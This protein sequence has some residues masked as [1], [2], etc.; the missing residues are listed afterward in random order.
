MVAVNVGA[1]SLGSLYNWTSPALPQLSRPDSWLPIDTEQASW[2]GS[3]VSLSSIFGPFIGGVS[4][5][6]IGRKSSM[7]VAVV[8]GLVAWAILYFTTAVWHIYVS[9][10]IAGLGGG[11]IFTSVPLYI[12]EI[13][14]VSLPHSARRFV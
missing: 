5:D 14:E 8:L 2:I 6:T 12:A 4:V 10:I 11:I 7:I 13:A 9:R 3:L 1:F